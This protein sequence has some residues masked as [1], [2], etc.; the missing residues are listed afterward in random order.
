MT[1]L[2]CKMFSAKVNHVR[3]ILG[4]GGAARVQDSAGAVHKQR[5][6]RQGDARQAVRE[7][8]ERGDGS[9]RCQH[10]DGAEALAGPQGR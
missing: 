4:A 10:R 1:T 6:H 5:A 2:K 8:A 9:V 7:G 3:L